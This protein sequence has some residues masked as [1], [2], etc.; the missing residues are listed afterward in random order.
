MMARDGAAVGGYRGQMSCGQPSLGWRVAAGQGVDDLTQH[1][2]SGVKDADIDGL[3][4]WPGWGAQLAKM[5]RLVKELRDAPGKQK[6]ASK[7]KVAAPPALKVLSVLEQLSG[8]WCLS[9]ATLWC[10]LLVLCDCLCLLLGVCHLSSCYSSG[11]PCACALLTGKA[12]A[13]AA[14]AAAREAGVRLLLVVLPAADSLKRRVLIALARGE[15]Q[16]EAVGSDGGGA[17]KGSKAAKSGGSQLSSSAG[18][19]KARQQFLAGLF[20]RSWN[21][22]AAGHDRATSSA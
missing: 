17:S 7:H 5:T 10:L 3:G 9:W 13:A 15:L 1:D 12:A 14:A 22:E 2:C 21:K 8:A 19:S 18:K 11:M 20:S 6:A 16:A 4:V